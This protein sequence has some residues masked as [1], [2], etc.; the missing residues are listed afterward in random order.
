MVISDALAS[1]ATLS[2]FIYTTIKIFKKIKQRRQFTLE[3]RLQLEHFGTS[4]G[5]S[6][7]IS[8]QTDPDHQMYRNISA[9]LR[10]DVTP[11]NYDSICERYQRYHR[12]FREARRREENTLRT[13]ANAAPAA[14][15]SYSEI[16]FQEENQLPT[17]ESL[18][19]QIP[20]KQA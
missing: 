16:M 5:T 9:V 1:V 13:A 20:Q 17:Y 15:P 12:L 11:E 8:T 7:F 14:P 2:L 19:E 10:T 6:P 18:I 4:F 3:N